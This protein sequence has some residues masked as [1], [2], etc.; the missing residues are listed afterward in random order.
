MFSKIE[1]GT[2]NDTKYWNIKQKFLQDD[3]FIDDL[4]VA[5]ETYI[6][7]QGLRFVF[8]FSLLYF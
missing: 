6:T 5:K 2:E 1:N 8:F 4:S 3:V 7:I